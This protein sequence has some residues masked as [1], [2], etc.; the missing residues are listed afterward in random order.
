MIAR[1]AIVAA[2]RG[3][4]GTPYRHQASLKGVG[5]DCLGLVRG[6]WREVV[7]PEPEPLRPYAQEWPLA[8]PDERLLDLAVMVEHV[9]EER[10]LGG[11]R[12]GLSARLGAVLGGFGRHDRLGYFVEDG[13][14]SLSF[15][16]QAAA[17]SMPGLRTILV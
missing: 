15:A 2:A 14:R 8:S 5:C 4:I 1:A 7:G 16:R 6:V 3:W 12:L 9:G 10:A 13:H 11:H 17:R